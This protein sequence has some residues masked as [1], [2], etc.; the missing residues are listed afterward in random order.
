MSPK[1]V[2][3]GMKCGYIYIVITF[4]DTLPLI[5]MCH[6]IRRTNTTVYIV[7][8]NAKSQLKKRETAKLTVKLLLF[9]VSVGYDYT[10][11]KTGLCN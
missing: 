8:T 1:P 6:I 4:D 2:C 10:V 9:P 7:V 3:V 11:D 5:Y